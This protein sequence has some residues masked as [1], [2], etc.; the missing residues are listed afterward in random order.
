MIKVYF[1]AT[2]SSPL[3]KKNYQR[4]I[5]ALEKNESVSLLSGKQTANKELLRQ[6]KKRSSKKIFAREK[7]FVD[8]ADLLIAEVTHP[9]TGVGGEIVY[10]LTQ[11]KPVLALIFE[12]NE[13]TITPMLYG[14]PS[15]NLFIE[16]YTLEN[17][18]LKLNAFLT[19]TDRLKS[20]K[21]KLIVIDGGDGSGK[22]TQAKLLLEYL[23]KKK[24][25]VKYV[26]FPQY[27][28]SFYGK[29][30]AMFLRG[31]FGA[32]NSV[33]PYLASLAY[34]SDR[35]SVKEEMEEFLEGGG[36]IIANRYATSNMAHQAA[37][38]ADKKERESY[39]K[40]VYEL[41]YKINKIPR[42]DMVIYLYVPWKIG[43]ALTKSKAGRNK[44][45]NG[46]ALDIA[47]ADTKHRQ[48]AEKMYLTLAKKYLHWEK[49]DCFENGVL[50]P[51][52]VIHQ[53][54]LSRLT[55]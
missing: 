33:S 45:L 4:I 26:D 12:E 11:K 22:A 19:H 49:I 7:A 5:A 46:K 16:H 1:T 43:Y 23:K 44:Y 8:Q 37:R 28:S 32:L 3:Y 2:T 41:E 51:I 13:D 35:A 29:T 27:Y 39:L 24:I 14:N 34:A 54:I 30:V 9:S 40:W 47:E 50:L 17:L 52:E 18:H 10:A 21:G 15:E 38:I 31:E 55:F 48:D 42:E 53:K 20:K 6:D 25:K 36:V